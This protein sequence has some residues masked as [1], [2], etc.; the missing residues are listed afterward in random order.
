MQ[1]LGIDDSGR[2]PVIGPMVLAGVLIDRKTEL[3]FRKLGVRDSKLLTAK[4]REFLAKQIKNHAYSFQISLT[5]PEEIDTRTNSGTNLNKIEAIKTAEIINQLTRNINQQNEKIKIIVD[6]PSPNIEKWQA[7]LENLIESP[8]KFIISCE[9]KADKNHIAVSAASILA[10]SQREKEIKKIKKQIGK[11]FGSG[12]SSDPIT[13]NFLKKHYSKHKK[14][15]LF[16]E[17]WGTVKNHIKQKEQMN[18][19]NF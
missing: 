10:K 9:H 11:D 4:R 14:T 15:G 8:E 19:N 7:F 3:K 13:Q 18:L 6:C 1:I 2:G 17:T 12:Y 16:R 5:F